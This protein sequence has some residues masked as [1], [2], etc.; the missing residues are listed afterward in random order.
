[1]EGQE[2]ELR[3]RLGQE[4]V[5][6][7]VA[8]RRDLRDVGLDDRGELGGR[9]HRDD[10]ALGDDLAQTRHR[11]GRAAQRRDLSGGRGSGGCLGRRS[12]GSGGSR[13]AR[14]GGGEHILLAD[15]TSDAGARHRVELDALL[16]G[17][18]AHDGGDVPDARRRGGGRGGGGGSL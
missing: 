17:E 12:R 8:Q 10:G 13:R 7:L 3:A 9:R 4:V 15:A 18:L 11:H 16:G 1:E 5:F 14:R 6:H 2:R